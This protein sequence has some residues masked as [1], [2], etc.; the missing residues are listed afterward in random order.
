V[1]D[2]V[3]SVGCQPAVVCI[4]ALI[5]FAVPELAMFYIYYPFQH[6]SWFSLFFAAAVRTIQTVKRANLLTKFAC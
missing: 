5:A 1:D 2:G 4:A 6:V 3:P